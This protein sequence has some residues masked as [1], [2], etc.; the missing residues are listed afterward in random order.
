[1]GKPTDITGNEK[2]LRGRKEGVDDTYGTSRKGV[3]EKTIHPGEDSNDGGGEGA[4]R[5]AASSIYSR[6]VKNTGGGG[7]DLALTE[8]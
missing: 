3:A 4:L 8:R 5:T 1:M 7:G 6:A 2:Y